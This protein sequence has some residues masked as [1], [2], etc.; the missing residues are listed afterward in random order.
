[1]TETGA[2]STAEEVTLTADTITELRN[3]TFAIVDNFLSLDLANRLLSEAESLISDGKFK[4]HYFQFGASVLSKPA[5]Y[6]L[7]LSAPDDA[8]NKDISSNLGSQSSWKDMIDHVGP[9]F[10]K[11]V[12]GFDKQFDASNSSSSSSSSCAPAL[13]LDTTTRPAI[14][15]QINTGGGSF[16]WHYDNPGP[17]N[18]RALTCVVY[19]NP[20]WKH[21]DGGEIVLWPFVSKPTTISPLHCRAVLFYS[22]RVLHRVLPSKVRRVC[23]TIWSQSHVVNSKKDVALSKDVLQFR[24]YDEAAT[25][26]AN[27]PLQRVISRAVYS[28][29]YLESLLECIEGSSRE[30]EK[31]GTMISESIISAV[32]KEKVIKQ[33]NASVQSIL[34]KLRPLIEE[35]RRRKECIANKG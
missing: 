30:K 18:Q 11:T 15:I 14:K 31:E 2:V 4:Q 25:F 32:D 24:S 5:V 23:F 13:S 1:M 7:D 16:P 9:E 26:F 29:E 3:N 10:V 28:E 6:E 35:F 19:L 27:S 20:R 17:P 12:D 21:G 8:M 34:S 33:H 22:D